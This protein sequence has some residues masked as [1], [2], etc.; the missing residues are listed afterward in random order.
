MF[1]PTLPTRDQKIFRF[2]EEKIFASNILIEWKSKKIFMCWDFLKNIN[3]SFDRTTFSGLCCAPNQ[4]QLTVFRERSSA[5]QAAAASKVEIYNANTLAAVW[6][7]QD[8]P[9]PG[10]ALHTWSPLASLFGPH[11]SLMTVTILIRDTWCSGEVAA[12]LPCLW[13][14]LSDG[15]DTDT[16]HNSLHAMLPCQA[17]ELSKW[18]PLL[19]WGW[20]PAWLSVTSYRQW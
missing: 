20:V 6:V 14:D 3:V 17:P 4:T 16:T 15:Q 9:Q 12:D 7:S 2:S 19:C 11:C 8:K 1:R 13:S 5:G 10:P 18:S